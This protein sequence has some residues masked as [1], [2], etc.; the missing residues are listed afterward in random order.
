MKDLFPDLT[1]SVELRIIN[2][3]LF[4]LEIDN[5]KRLEKAS[6]CI[7]D[8]IILHCD[9]WHLADLKR[10]E[11][12]EEKY[13]E[14]ID[15]TVNLITNIFKDF[16]IEI[17]YELIKD[18]VKNFYNINISAPNYYSIK[19]YIIRKIKPLIEEGV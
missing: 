11:M 18:I 5:F 14:I 4:N 19:E 1:N 9:K 3:N 8:K 15:A 7:N 12:T 17:D 10:S 2:Q 6:G 16:S 13:S